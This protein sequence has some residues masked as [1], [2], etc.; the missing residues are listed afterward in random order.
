[1]KLNYG[2]YFANKYESHNNM[3]RR[4]YFANPTA[5]KTDKK[6]LQKV[7]D[8][9]NDLQSGA[10]SSAEIKDYITT[11]NAFKATLPVRRGGG[12]V[13]FLRQC[14]ECS[15]GLFHAMCY[16]HESINFCPIHNERLL[17]ECP[18]CHR[19]F[20]SFRNTT[21][22]I[23]GCP[24]CGC[25]DSEAI[26]KKR[27]EFQGDL[28]RVLNEFYA[29]FDEVEL[30]RAKY[31][32]YFYRPDGRLFRAPNIK[33][34]ADVITYNI[35]NPHK[36]V[37]NHPSTSLELRC[38][39]SITRY[40]IRRFEVNPINY[41]VVDNTTSI[42][43]DKEL[44]IYKSFLSTEMEVAYEIVKMLR[45]VHKSRPE[46]VGCYPQGDPCCILCRAFSIWYSGVVLH[47][48]VDFRFGEVLDSHYTHFPRPLTNLADHGSFYK[49]PKEES[50]F[51]YR[52]NLIGY[53]LFVFDY[54]VHRKLKSAELSTRRVRFPSPV[55]DSFFSLRKSGIYINILYIYFAIFRFE[56]VYYH[57]ELG[58]VLK[59]MR[60][61][62]A[63]RSNDYS[64]VEH[65]PRYSSRSIQ[66]HPNPS[67]YKSM[68]LR[69]FFEVSSTYLIRRQAF[70]D[71]CAKDVRRLG[72]PI[73]I[74]K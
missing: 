57:V 66:A 73:I 17:W 3:A 65:N 38:S 18:D 27:R 59:M 8:I 25:C 49:I 74:R 43:L 23:L 62:V 52:L 20:S 71:S 64:K 54:C 53:F 28:D 30:V 9:T 61:Y 60:D 6:F 50:F 21:A 32:V 45:S 11:S 22:I 41:P 14:V 7:K 35:S 42:Y 51:L 44:E 68:D 19:R 48:S 36:K 37:D 63:L 29:S 4:I 2:L 31:A 15:R 40:S 33:D 16:Q 12:F 39:P 69:Q 26:A 24:T 67:V 5:R 56:L 46:D 47:K 55:G 58:D 34:A 70:L 13:P 1:M 10:T 72:N